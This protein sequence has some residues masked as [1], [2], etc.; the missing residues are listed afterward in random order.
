MAITAPQTHSKSRDLKPNSILQIYFRSQPIIGAI[1]S[2]Q[3]YAL[4][5]TRIQ[6]YGPY[7]WLR[8]VLGGASL[9]GRKLR[10][11]ATVELLARDVNHCTV[12]RRVWL[13]G[14]IRERSKVMRA[15]TQHN[16]PY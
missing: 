1:A 6:G 16:G 11:L 14:P 12:L 3:I 13:K 7:T 4:I 9:I 10:S 2:A 8:Y 15:L 5:E